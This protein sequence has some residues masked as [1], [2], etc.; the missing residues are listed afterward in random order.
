LH[1]NFGRVPAQGGCKDQRVT[2]V[3]PVSLA[4]D[5]FRSMAWSVVTPLK[6]LCRFSVQAAE[7]PMVRNAIRRQQSGFASSSDKYRQM[8]KGGAF[9]PALTRPTLTSNP[10]L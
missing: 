7:L 4:F 6:Y 10:P 1:E 8:A 5:L 3:K 2:R 9:G